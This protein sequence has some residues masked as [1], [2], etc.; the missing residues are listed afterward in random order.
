M[1]AHWSRAS[2]SLSPRLSL[3]WSECHLTCA[4]APCTCAAIFGADQGVDGP[5]IRQLD[6]VL[7]TSAGQCGGSF[8][9]LVIFFSEI[10]RARTGWMEPKIAMSTL[11]PEYSVITQRGSKPAD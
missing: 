2:G 7:Q 9:L 1:R 3:P 8:L 5:V 4:Y 11:R 6:E 10:Y